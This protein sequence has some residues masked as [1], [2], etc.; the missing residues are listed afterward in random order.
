MFNKIFK[1]DFKFVFRLWWIYAL[2]TAGLALIGGA[3]LRGIIEFITANIDN[4][5][6]YILAFLGFFTVIIGLCCFPLAAVIICLV[7][8]YKNFYSDEGYL[9]F[10]LPVKRTSLL[11]SKILTFLLFEI[12]SVAVLII[13][14]YLILVIGIKGFHTELANLLPMLLDELK[15]IWNPSLTA[16]VIIFPFLLLA[17]ALMGINLYYL[18][19]TVGSVISKRYKVLAA[20]GIYL[21]VSVAMSFIQQIISSFTISNLMFTSITYTEF[22]TNG[23]EFT[24]YLGLMTLLYGGIAIGAYFI[25]LHCIKNKLNLS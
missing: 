17:S 23:A 1:Y 16:D 15:E 25:N 5:L 4:F 10:T 3:L 14:I 21:G 19:F 9:T 13:D 20:L 22:A 7:R 18:C 8:Y 12:M 6:F 2:I 11:N 24:I